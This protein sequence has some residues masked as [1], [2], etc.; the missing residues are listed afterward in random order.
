MFKMLFEFFF[1]VLIFFCCF[2]D[3]FVKMLGFIE[4][5][6][7]SDFDCDLLGDVEY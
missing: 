2:F 5:A 7:I 4:P 1:P 3:E 6:D